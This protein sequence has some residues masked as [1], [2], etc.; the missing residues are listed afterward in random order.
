MIMTP[1]FF[2][3]IG[4]TAALAAVALLGGCGGGSQVHHFE[5]QR[6]VALGDEYSVIGDGS[7]GVAAGV[8]YT[9]NYVDTNKLTT[10][11]PCSYDPNWVQL[12]AA[13]KFAI[14]FPGCQANLPAAVGVMRAQPGFTAQDVINDA[15]SW[16]QFQ[17]GDLVT[18]LAGANDILNAY[19]QYPSVPLGT[20]RQTLKAA[21]QALGEWITQLSNAHK[22]LRILA[23]T[24]PDLGFSPLAYH[25]T[26]SAAWT[27]NTLG[28][29]KD[30]CVDPN[31]GF[32]ASPTRQEVLSRLT[33]CFNAGLR[34]GL[35]NASGYYVG[36]VL[37]DQMTH[38]IL[39][40][41]APA[42][43][44]FTDANDASCIASVSAPNCAITI[45]PAPTASD[46]NAYIADFSQ[47]V[48]T[49]AQNSYFWA[50]AY[51]PSHPRDSVWLSPGG[52][53][54]LYSAASQTFD[55]NPF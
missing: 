48:A 19:Q 53:A 23:V 15:N 10:P 44:G 12:L 3:R 47:L 51:D 49:G 5:P 13:Q 30:N 6:V 24:V 54:Q 37:A 17:G 52:Q 8:K 50:Y 55:T 2:K 20:L 16:N 31:S 27:T 11:Y 45:T 34:D 43:Y 29:F 21:G 41:A 18:V 39:T 9:V 40:D 35:T 38:N 22:D 42:S 32:N 33:E 28:F 26:P 14:T 25:D 7:N 1:Q 36:L 4:W 46:P